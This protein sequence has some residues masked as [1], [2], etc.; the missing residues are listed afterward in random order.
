MNE[1]QKQ[2]ATNSQEDLWENY[3]EERNVKQEE[4]PKASISSRVERDLLEYEKTEKRKN[5]S[6]KSVS[7]VV[8]IGIGL[9]VAAIFTR[10]LISA[11]VDYA[12]DIIDDYGEEIVEVEDIDDGYMYEGNMDITRPAFYVGSNGYELPVP[13][14]QFISNGWVM[15]SENDTVK[16]D[17]IK[18]VSLEMDGYYKLK[19]FVTAVNDEECK[20]ENATVI[21]VEIPSDTYATLPGDIYSF[22][23]SYSL[24]QI[25]AENGLEWTKNGK[26]TE[27]TY[28]IQSEV[29]NDSEYKYCTITLKMEEDIL[30]NTV[31]QLSKTK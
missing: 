2:A 1:Q 11:P 12:E 25:F 16:K 8:L 29:E 6:K 22:A 4:S 30:E 7:I 31:I 28:V 10:L 23:S 5:R 15:S 20:I 24:E 21:G 14:K 18:E 3:F 26:G 13:L 17:E 9:F 27:S 19:A